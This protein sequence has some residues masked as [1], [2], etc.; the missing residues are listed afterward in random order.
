[1]SPR[2]SLAYAIIPMPAGE[3]L[4]AG[5]DDGVSAL[6]IVAHA[7]MPGALDTLRSYCQGVPLVPDA[8]ALAGVTRQLMEYLAGT[9]QAFDV[10]L[11]LIGTPFQRRVWESL[12]TIPYGE[13]LTYRE[14][15]FALNK[16]GGSQA[17]GG[18]VGRNPVSIIVPCH[19]VLGSDG[20]LT[21][22][23]WGTHVKRW[24]LDHE[25]QHSGRAAA[26]SQQYLFPV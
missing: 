26:S 22:Y 9:R 10:P 14:V 15:A 23:M 19:R 11:A 7:A 25:R 12:L 3:I 13:T 8:N 16:P 18:A 6:I 21:G 2:E 4:V 5:T 17:V 24:L 20:S 1:M